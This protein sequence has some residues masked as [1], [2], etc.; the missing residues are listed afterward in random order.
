MMEDK[1]KTVLI[2]GFFVQYRGRLL[3]VFGA[4]FIFGMWFWL[5]NSGLI[6]P[7]YL[8]SPQSIIQC[9]IRYSSDM[10]KHIGDS[11]YRIIIGFTIGSTL[12][13]LVGLP[14][15]WSKIL[16]EIFEPVVEF[17][18]PMPPL[19]LIPLIILWFGIGNDSKI[20]LISF[21]CWVILVVNTIE[22]VRNIDPLY[23]NAARTLGAH[24][25]KLFRTIIFPAIIPSIMGGIRVAA[26]TSFGMS[27]ASEF[28][29]TKAGFGYLIIE[30]RRFIM[31]DLLF[32]GIIL[33]TIFSMLFN[34]IIK[35]IELHFT[36][37][38]PR[39]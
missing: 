4:I 5:S 9:F 31:T 39:K 27:V 23:I 7:L 14:I 3:N 38:V 32:L 12:G 34:S 15:G 24:G 30:G 36:R 18:R 16:G 11:M 17:I 35:H 21:G 19:A 26:A 20:I 10:P 29:G 13:I 33:I 28:M 6:N 8:P 25:L 37:W 2:K 22:A 1:K